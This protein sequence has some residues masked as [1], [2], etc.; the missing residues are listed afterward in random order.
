M[1]SKV[2]LPVITITEESSPKEARY[3]EWNYSDSMG[4]NSNLR[5]FAQ[6]KE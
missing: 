5:G 2:Q 4:L 1:V 3:N 6:G